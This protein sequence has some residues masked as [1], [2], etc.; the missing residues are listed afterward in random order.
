[1][2]ATEGTVLV[3]RE[4]DLVAKRMGVSTTVGDVSVG[5]S[6]MGVGK[7]GDSIPYTVS[8][9]IKPNPE[10][11]ALVSILLRLALALVKLYVLLVCVFVCRGRITPEHS[12]PTHCFLPIIVTPRLLSL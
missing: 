6:G 8:E 7:S 4:G 3:R 1:M 9:V 12:L 11:A 10:L 2:V 5:S